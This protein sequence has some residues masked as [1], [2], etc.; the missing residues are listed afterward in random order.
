[1]VVLSLGPFFLSKG[2]AQ[3][4]LC[5]DQWS[6]FPLALCLS[7]PLPFPIAMVATSPTPTAYAFVFSL[8]SATMQAL[9]AD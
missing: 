9:E 3:A 6:L 1:M 5:W 8:Y 2:A 4:D 7:G